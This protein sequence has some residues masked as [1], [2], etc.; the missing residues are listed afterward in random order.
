MKIFNFGFFL[1]IMC[2]DEKYSTT[3]LEY[4]EFVINSKSIEY[5]VAIDT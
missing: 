5:Q 1:Y 4:L 2:Y 3:F